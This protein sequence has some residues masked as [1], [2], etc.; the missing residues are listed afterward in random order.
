VWLTD[1]WSY[2]M[3]LARDQQ[4]R[5]VADAEQCVVVFDERDSKRVKS[6]FS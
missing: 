2:L 3:S 4:E 6:I 5:V 1:V